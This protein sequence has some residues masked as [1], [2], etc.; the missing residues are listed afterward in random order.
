MRI[1][2]IQTDSKTG[3]VISTVGNTVVYTRMCLDSFIKHLDNYYIVLLVNA[4]PDG[5]SEELEKCAT[6]DVTVLRTDGSVS[7]AWNAGIKRCLEAD[8]GMVILSSH[9][10]YVDSSIKHLVEE[11]RSCP[12]DAMRYY[13]PLMSHE[14]EQKAGDARAK[15]G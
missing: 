2:N 9:D 8:C 13:E 15:G 14:P 10:L 4:D 12:P 3:V 1:P 6:Q 11:T 7:L 5:G